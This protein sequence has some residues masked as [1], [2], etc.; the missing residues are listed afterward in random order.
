[1]TRR[2]AE[3]CIL[4][5]GPADCQAL[6]YHGTRWYEVP[7]KTGI[8]KYE[9]TRHGEYMFAGEQTWPEFRAAYRKVLN[10]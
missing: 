7:T 4:R 10:V 3:T 9:L 8:A 6:P 1:M 5:G 2:L